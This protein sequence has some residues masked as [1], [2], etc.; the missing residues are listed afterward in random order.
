MA[1]TLLVILLTACALVTC[2]WQ[3]TKLTAQAANKELELRAEM[4]A[5]LWVQHLTYDLDGFARLMTGGA[6]ITP[7]AAVLQQGMGDENV[8]WFRFFD[9]QGGLLLERS[10]TIDLPTLEHIQNRARDVD[11]QPK[12][13]FTAPEPATEI[14]AHD[15][16]EDSFRYAETYFPLID[17]GELTGYFEIYTDMTGIEQDIQPLFRNLVMSVGLLI[18]S[19]MLVPLLFLFV[20][21]LK[22]ERS[23]SHLMFS[24]QRA[25]DAERT[26]AEFL[27]IMSH[28]IR[29]PMNGVIAMAE[30]LEQSELNSEQ[31]S[32]TRTITQ[33]SVALLSIINDILDFS[34]IDAGKMRVHNEPFDLGS[35]VQ[36]AAALFSPSI[37]SKPVEIVVESTVAPPFFVV[38]D[39]ARLRQCLLN[40]IGNAVK[41]TLEGNVHI[42]IGRTENGDV[43]IK[44]S[45][46]GVG[47][48]EDMLDHIFDEFAQI[49]DGRTRRFEGTGLGLAITLRL[50]HLME[51]SLSARSRHG[52]GSVFEFRF[53]FAPADAPEKETQFW[54]RALQTLSGRRVMVIEDL[55][56]NR[57]ALRSLLSFFDIKPVFARDGEGATNLLA[58]LL[59]Q[60][61]PPHLI[62]IDGGLPD[63]DS[64][65]LRSTLSGLPGA[66]AI[67]SV[68]M[69]AAGQD[70]SSERLEELGFLTAIRK[71]LDAHGLAGVLCGSLGT[72]IEND[73]S[74]TPKSGEKL[75]LEGKTVLLAED[76]ATNRLVIEKLLAGSGITLEMAHNGRDA[77]SLYE[78]IRPDLVL[79]DVSMPLMNGYD[80]TIAIRLIEKENAI[81]ACPIVALTANA[82]P[83]DRLE[84]SDAG[85]SDFLPKPV[86]RAELLGTLNDWLAPEDQAQ[87]G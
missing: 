37:A 75:E 43:S 48:P 2:L 53:P 78:K 56:V 76:N 66:E 70:V 40:V 65:T 86:R 5:R 8:V 29:T 71:P 21:W 7:D 79:M 39:S 69:I 23:N 13:I 11:R 24:R 73:Q 60:G 51:G 17:D 28:E 33:S 62:L 47:I 30:L 83:E 44:V 20:F 87:A 63:I 27:A 18:V 49:E 42:W 67:P 41:F 22:L 14:F 72:A 34:K 64:K 46:T 9:P 68:L 31:R 55:E 35:L 80:A 74:E 82:L 12:T 36:D 15:T 32:L 1:R 25:E 38:G 85:M 54:S 61:T 19:A 50:T 3:V 77:V 4:S 52:H 57:R 10:D 84:C 58:A 16:S 59:R 81:S 45:D 6:A 26:K